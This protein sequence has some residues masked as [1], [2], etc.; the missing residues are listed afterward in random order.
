MSR[1]WK[2]ARLEW[3]ALRRTGEKVKN[4]ACHTILSRGLG[5]RISGETVCGIRCGVR[6]CLPPIEGVIP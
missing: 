3:T 4:M 1:H 6:G 2:A 5:E